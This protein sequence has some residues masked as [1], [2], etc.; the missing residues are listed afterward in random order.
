M[1]QSQA[2]E[3]LIEKE[4][5][6]SETISTPVTISGVVIPWKKIFS[7]EKKSE[8]NL[9]CPS[10]VSYLIVA[11]SEWRDILSEYTWQQVKVKGLLNV[12]KMTILPENILPNGPNGETENVIDIAEW[13]KPKPAH[14]RAQSLND[15]VFIPAAVW[16]I[17]A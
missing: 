8:Y 1:R 3:K 12:S 16:T 9:V 15:C 6:K 5:K 2:L 7:R 13:K 4:Q 14:K 17:I 11:D 10:G